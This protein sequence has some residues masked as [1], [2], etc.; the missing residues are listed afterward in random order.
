MSL[1]DVRLR[2]FAFPQGWDGAEIPLRILV[3]PFG[4]PLLS[5]DPG[6]APFAQARLALSAHLI[7]GVDR[8]PRPADVTERVLLQADTPADVKQVY[9]DVAARFDVDPAAPAAYVP[10]TKTRF[11]KM[12]MP[13]YL[14]AS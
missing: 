14:E 13:S 9:T 8:L 6:L 7:P 4:N 5:L 3:A 11:L 1:A 2:I 12:L 10:P